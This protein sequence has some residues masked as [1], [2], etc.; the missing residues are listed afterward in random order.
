MD[1]SQDGTDHTPMERGLTYGRDSAGHVFSV[2]PEPVGAVRGIDDR[3]TREEFAECID[4]ALTGLATTDPDW[5]AARWRPSI[6]LNEGVSTIW[7]AFQD[8]GIE[9]LDAEEERL[10]LSMYNHFDDLSESVLTDRRGEIL[11]RLGQEANRLK[12][13]VR[14]RA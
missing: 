6:E 10:V 4:L 14:R 9:G 8:D 12:D 3:L 13:Y 7:V 2:P 1:G 5:S 11:G